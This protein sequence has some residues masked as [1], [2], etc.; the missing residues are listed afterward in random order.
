MRG[1]A[2]ALVT[3]MVAATVTAC[4]LQSASGTVLEAQ[5]G[6]IQHYESLE[7]VPVTVAAK[8]FT[9][10][11]ILGNMLSIILNAAGAAPL[12]QV[13]WLKLVAVG[14]PSVRG[15]SSHGCQDGP[16]CTCTSRTHGMGDSI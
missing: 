11:L 1:C 2:A 12:L 13:E 14:V 15:S 8:D 5:P 16:A 4:G 3:A 10:Q 7:G 6:A 9:E